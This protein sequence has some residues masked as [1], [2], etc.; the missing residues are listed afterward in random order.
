MFVASFQDSQSTIKI[1]CHRANAVFL[2]VLEI[3]NARLPDMHWAQFQVHC[4]CALSLEAAVRI[5]LLLNMRHDPATLIGLRRYC[6]E[7]KN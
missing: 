1:R 2:F 5:L 7:T 3:N 4:P 6:F